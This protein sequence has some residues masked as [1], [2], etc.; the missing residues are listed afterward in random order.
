M[1]FKK[2]LLP[3]CIASVLAVGCSSG[4][5][6]ND[7]DREEEVTSPDT[8]TAGPIFDPANGLIPTTNDLLFAGSVDGTL[9]IPNVD[10]N[11]VIAAVNK[12]DGFST[13]APMVASF[14]T[15]ID[16]TTLVV[17]DSVRVFEVTKDANGLVTA[18]NGELSASQIA[19]TTSGDDNDSL[20]LIPLQP[21]KAST[22]YMVVLTSGIN[23]LAGES[24]E[25]V[26][27][28]PSTIYNLTKVLAD[29]PSGSPLAALN[30][31]R[32]FTVAME[33]AAVAQ[34]E[35]L[36][37]S[38]IVLSWSFTTQSISQT[39][40]T[41]AADVEAGSMGEVNTA[42]ISP[43]GAAVISTSTLDIPYYLEKPSEA[44]PVAAVTGYWKGVGGSDLTR[45]NPSPVVNETLTIP[46]LISTPNPATGQVMPATGWPVVMFQHGITRNR[47]DMLAVADSLAQ[48]GFAVVSIDLPLHGVTDQSDA[49]VLPFKTENEFTFGIDYLTE[50]ADGNVTANTP[51]GVEDSS[52]SSFLNLASLLTSRDNIRQG[53]LNLLV[54]RK[55]LETS[56]SFSGVTLDGSQIGFV[57]HSLGGIVGTVYL[58]VEDS[59]TTSSLV[60]T[61][62]GIPRLLDGSEVFG[63]T[64]RAGL[65]AQGV[66]GDAYQ[67]YLTGAQWVLDSADPINYAMDAAG[68][69]SIHMIE[70]IGDSVIPNAVATGPLSGTEP[71]AALMGLESITST[72]SSASGVNGIV[73][74]SEGNHGSVLDPAESTDATVEMQTEIGAYQASFGQAIVITNPSVIQGAGPGGGAGL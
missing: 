31:L 73:R 14:G 65:A 8:S 28:V 66:V 13:S 38:D 39:L 22:S 34:D 33:S 19:V 64:I 42:G 5:S 56:P 7:S 62:G 4:S 63:D 68:T 6:D 16:P 36:S 55:T 70:V 67:S 74:F 20:L 9:N 60:T 69:H 44:N 18:V 46:V 52:G 27:A 45:F 51:D 25:A 15:P 53:A 29:Y 58:G 37:S 1:K 2:W 61:G 32:P 17:G 23:V 57:G 40:D 21:L 35:S 59:V 71:L 50:D 24:G 12:L 11:P 30:A 10:E 47:T 49:Q 48:A 26:A 41:L 72:Q 3:I 43:L 54:L